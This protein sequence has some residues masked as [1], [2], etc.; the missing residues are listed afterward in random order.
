MKILSWLYGKGISGA[1]SS[2]LINKYLAIKA[3]HPQEDETKIL[4]R[5]WNLWLT[6]NEEKIMEE[7]NEDKII[8]LSIKKEQNDKNAPSNLLEAFSDILYIETEVLMQ[9]GDLWDRAVQVFLKE[10]K[11]QGLDFTNIYESQRI[12]LE[13]LGILGK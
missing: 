2:D 8:R 4:T 9:D 1:I 5:V 11:K 3:K 12:I 7:N 10:S 13:R 6:M